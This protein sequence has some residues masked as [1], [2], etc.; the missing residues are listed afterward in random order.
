M[1]AAPAFRF[2]GYQ[3]PASVHT[4]AGE[5]LGE[6]IASR[7][8]DALPFSFERN[9]V[10]AG[11]KAADLLDM[12]ERGQLTACYFSSSYLASRAPELAVLDLPFP[13]QSRE[14]AYAAL[15]G[16]LGA[17]LSASMAMRSPSCTAP[18]GPPA[19]ASGATC[20]MHKPR[21]PPENRPSVTRAT[22]SPNPAPTRAAGIIE[23]TIFNEN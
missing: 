10:D 12:V 19:A 17:R 23:T 3:G 11:H 13:V 9:V 2:G 1:S 7:L 20:P 6:A 16:D 14:A 18:I 4:R 22:L 15:D 5:V 8:G 21:V